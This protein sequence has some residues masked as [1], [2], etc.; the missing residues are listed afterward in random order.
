MEELKFNVFLLS[1]K[2]FELEM[3]DEWKDII[4]EFFSQYSEMER[5]TE[6]REGHLHIGSIGVEFKFISIEDIKP[7]LR[8]LQGEGDGLFIVFGGVCFKI[9]VGGID[10]FF[11]VIDFTGQSMDT[12]DPRFRAADM[13]IR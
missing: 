3:F 9:S 5:G 11:D 6:N 7:L 1:Y 10:L 8:L 4:V 13:T 2:V 12:L